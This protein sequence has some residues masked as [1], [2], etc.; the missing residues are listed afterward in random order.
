[1]ALRAILNDVRTRLLAI[2]GMTPLVYIYEPWA[3][4]TSAVRALYVTNELL[5]A[6]TITRRS[7]LERRLATGHENERVYTLIL[8]GYYA[9][10][11]LDYGG[12]ITDPSLL[13]FNDELEAICTTFRLIPSLG[14]LA[15][16]TEPVQIDLVEPRM[17]C[18]VLCHAAELRLEVQEL[19]TW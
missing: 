6:W 9:L 12:V 14:G 13:V 3:A 18:E 1:M 15:E 5:H 8:R 2:P 10:N 16:I 11:N 19:I 7:A 4:Q 17:F